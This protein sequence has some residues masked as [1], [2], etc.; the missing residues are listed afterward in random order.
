MND[1]LALDPKRLLGIRI[2]VAHSPSF[3]SDGADAKIG[4][5]IG[6][7]LPVQASPVLSAKIGSKDG[8]KDR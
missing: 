2:A 4:S 3:T 8:R 5:K 6:D 1:Q 7:K